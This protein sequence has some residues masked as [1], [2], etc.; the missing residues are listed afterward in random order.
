[1]AFA[2]SRH[3]KLYSHIYLRSKAIVLELSKV[4]FKGGGSRGKWE[5]VGAYTNL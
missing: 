4:S 3:R 5:Q 2:T 1:M